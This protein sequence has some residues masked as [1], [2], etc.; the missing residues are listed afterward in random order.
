M[1]AGARWSDGGGGEESSCPSTPS[2][3]LGGEGVG[4]CLIHCLQFVADTHLLLC[5]FSASTPSLNEQN[6]CV[7]LGL[8]MSYVCFW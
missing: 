5:C 3:R 8:W 6:Y 1:R 2:P 7:V 4:R